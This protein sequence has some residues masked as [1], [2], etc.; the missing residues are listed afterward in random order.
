MPA[1]NV[2]NYIGASITSVINQTYSNWELIVIDDGSTDGTAGIVQ[3]FIEKD[4]RIKYLY[5]ENARQARA[6]NNGILHAKGSLLAFLD[7]DDLWL[8]TKLEQSL[9]VFDLERYDLVFTNTYMTAETFIDVSNASYDVMQVAAKE[10][11]GT[12][13]LLSFMEYN[14]VPTLT[15]LVKKSL[16]EQVG[17]FDENCV[18]AEDYDLWVRLLKNGAAF[19]SI[20]APLSIYRVQ[21][22]SSTASDR[23]ATA[24]VVTSIAKNFTAQELATLQ[25]DRYL[26]KWLLRWIAY[27]L[28]KTK[29]SELQAYVIHFNFNNKL[30]TLLF[31]FRSILGYQRFKHLITKALQ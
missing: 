5:Q 29:V 3:S 28:N 15:V 13:A 6:R 11:N 27:S 16:V 25:V 19:K 2:E 14:R 1:Y 21:E 12:E 22:A 4:G 23:L 18:P 8:P 9:V 30:I 10:Y 20:A 26:R 17:L 7:S 31:L 24:A